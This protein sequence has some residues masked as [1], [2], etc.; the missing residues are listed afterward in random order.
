[1]RRTIPA[2]LCV[3]LLVIFLGCGR[4]GSTPR[5]HV[6]NGLSGEG[7][8]LKHIG[9]TEPPPELRVLVELEGESQAGE[10]LH[11]LTTFVVLGTDQPEPNA[12]QI[13]ATYLTAQG[14]HLESPHPD[15]RQWRSLRGYRGDDQNSTAVSFGL[16]RD[17][18]KEPDTG[19]DADEL[20]AR[21]SGS[22]TLVLMRVDR[23]T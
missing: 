13:V 7:A 1:M 17:F 21:A 12:L 3:T 2:A 10:P 19:V 16:L 20:A 15:V 23:S 22:P 18:L 6:N 5:V 8:D 14:F 11:D 4:G 9:L